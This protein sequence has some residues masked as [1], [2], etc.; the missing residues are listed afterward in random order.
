MR[1][2][3]ELVAEMRG[4]EDGASDLGSGMDAVVGGHSELAIEHSLL[5]LKHACP[6][7]VMSRMGKRAHVCHDGCRSAS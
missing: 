6:T 1:Q 4:G 5:R 3:R 2:R 7:V